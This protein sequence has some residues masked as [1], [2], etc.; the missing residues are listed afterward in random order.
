MNVLTRSPSTLMR[1]GRCMILLRPVSVSRL[2]QTG[3]HSYCRFCCPT[4][5]CFRYLA[6]LSCTYTWTGDGAEVDNANLQDE[7]RTGLVAMLV[8]NIHSRY[9]EAGINGVP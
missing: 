2:S 9:L 3:G 7:N 8:D 6:V 1:I 5:T 4:S